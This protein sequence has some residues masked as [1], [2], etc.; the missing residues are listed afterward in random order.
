MIYLAYEEMANHTDKISF[1][2]M[3]KVLANWHEAGIKT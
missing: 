1:P 3:N 2:Y